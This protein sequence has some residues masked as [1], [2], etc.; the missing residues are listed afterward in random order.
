M[1]KTRIRRD[2]E[3]FKDYLNGIRHS[4]LKTMCILGFTLTPLFLALDYFM[5]HEGRLAN[6]AIYR[7]A[8]TFLVLA[9][10]AVLRS[11]KPSK[12]APFHG[13][14][15]SLL[16][17]IMISTMTHEL[18]GL[19][20]SYYAGLNLVMIAVIVLIPWGFSHAVINALLIIGSYLS[21]NFLFPIPF[22]YNI[23]VNNLYFLFSS[24]V[25]AVAINRVH[26]GL[27][28]K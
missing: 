26:F 18:G 16:L 22:H 5:I 4:W 24:A 3:D 19:D 17:G 12:Y 1:N 23:L 10:Y 27:I 28:R 25:I 21:V 11:T 8:V 7:G 13:Y 15:F 6:F 20:S 9:Q 2:T 14:L